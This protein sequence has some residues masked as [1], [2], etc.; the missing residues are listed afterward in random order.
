[1]KSEFNNI[2]NVIMNQEDHSYSE[3]EI[4]SKTMKE[5]LN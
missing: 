4:I 3:R 1:M 2:Q 5:T